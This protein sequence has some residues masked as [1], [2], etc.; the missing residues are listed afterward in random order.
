MI[1]ETLYKEG[2]Y[3]E[4]LAFVQENKNITFEMME[5]KALSEYELQ[6]LTVDDAIRYIKK[7]PYNKRFINQMSIYI[8]DER[9]SVVEKKKYNQE[10]TKLNTLVKNKPACWLNNQEELEYAKTN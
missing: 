8:S 7:Q 6:I 2:S 3:Q 5:L 10:I 4:L 9:Y 1:T